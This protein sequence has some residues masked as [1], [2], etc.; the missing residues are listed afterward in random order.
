MDGIMRLS[1][2]IF[3]SIGLLSCLVVQPANAQ[4][5]ETFQDAVSVS[6]DTFSESNLS[7]DPQD[8]VNQLQAIRL[9]ATQPDALFTFPAPIRRCQ[10]KANQAQ[11]CLADQCFI[12]TGL[13]LNTAM[14]GLS[15][16]LPG[17]D[18][19][20]MA[21]DMDF[22]VDWQLFDRGGPKRGRVFFGL[23]GRWEYG[24]P[25]PTDLG[26]ASLGSAITTANTYAAYNP[27]YIVRNL[28]WKQGS[29]EAGWAY[30]I[31]HVTPDQIFST[32]S[33]LNPIATFLTVAGTGSFANALPDSGLGA[34]VGF[35]LSDRLRVGS[36]I[37]DAN[38]NRLSW[39]AGDGELYKALE[40]QAKVLP[41]TEKGVWSKITFWHTDGTSDGLPINGMTGR[42]G[43][44]IYVIH[45]QELTCDGR[46]VAVLRWGRGFNESALFEQQAGAHL[47]V[48]DP[49][50][51]LLEHLSEDAWGAA[52]NWVK[53]SAAG[54]RDEYDLEAFYRFPLFP[55]TDMSLLYQSIFKPALA[56][57]ID[58]ASV[59]SIRFASSF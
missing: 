3:S 30:R 51:P 17:E 19:Y 46:A 39:G 49:C 53:S 21:T 44:G 43:W 24:P 10:E 45:E 34:V 18:K 5:D 31:G 13:A 1:V 40:F 33:R 6:S 23:E 42:E 36:G 16:A 4:D 26:P 22:I 58:H 32:S 48:D 29:P 25:G 9:R 14:Q 57:S 12:K 38:A 54:A 59:F 55:N 15:D 20:G 28:F 8:V 47:V 52:F 50:V 11:Q 41:L 56:P 37:H 35:A 7:D 27:T 2:I